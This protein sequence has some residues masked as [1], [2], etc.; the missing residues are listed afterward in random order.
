M[1]KKGR[2]GN[3]AGR[4]KGSKNRA[5]LLAIAAMEGELDAVVRKVIEAAKSGDM[6]AA[7]LVV[8]KLVPAAKD[9]PLG[10]DL[11]TLVDA[12]GCAEAQGK[13]VAAVAEGELLPSEG[14]A[15]SGLIEN[16]R[17]SFETLA[18]EQRLQAIEDRLSIG[19]R[20]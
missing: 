4:P 18:L 5:T 6:V 8:D 12:K 16:Q 15:L 20:K 13:V 11:P 10:I 1:F 14:H 2:S 17:R 7:R 3:P 9:R 19:A